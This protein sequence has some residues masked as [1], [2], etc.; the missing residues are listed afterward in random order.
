MKKSSPPTLLLP[1]VVP[2]LKSPGGNTVEGNREESAKVRICADNV[3]TDAVRSK[4]E[5]AAEENVIM[6]TVMD[7]Q[8]GAFELVEAITGSSSLY[9]LRKG[10][11]DL[12]QSVRERPS[13]ENAGG[14][15]HRKTLLAKI[16][17][18]QGIQEA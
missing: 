18:S 14:R 16:Q 10:D 2:P 8:E 6:D 11:V 9:S 15:R 5:T 3:Q 17:S 13:F 1:L 7:A 4:G 12:A